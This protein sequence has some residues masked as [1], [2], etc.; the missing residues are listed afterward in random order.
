M[1]KKSQL[2][3]GKPAVANKG[4]ILK[5]VSEFI[6]GFINIFIDNSSKYLKINSL[7]KQNKKSIKIKKHKNFWQG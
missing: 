3:S 4:P 5:I 2:L 7:F 1:K 6:Q